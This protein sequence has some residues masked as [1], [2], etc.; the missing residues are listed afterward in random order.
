MSRT[1]YKWHRIYYYYYYCYYCYYLPWNIYI[2]DSIK[3]IYTRLIFQLGMILQVED[4]FIRTVPP[5]SL[6]YAVV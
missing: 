3:W 4:N 5:P 2:L 1:F 6:H